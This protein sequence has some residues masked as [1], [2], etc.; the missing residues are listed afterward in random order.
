MFLYVTT[1]AQDT[2]PD[3]RWSRSYYYNLNVGES[4]I[5]DGVTIH[6]IYIDHQ[7]S[8]L[9]IEQDTIRLRVARR[10]LPVSSGGFQIFVAD[11]RNVANLTPGDPAHGLLKKDALICVSKINS[12][13]WLA[14]DQFIFPVSF[15]HGFI[16]K[17]DEDSYIFSLTGNTKDKNFTSYSGIGIDLND[18][19]GKEKHWLLAIENSNVVWVEEPDKNTACVL[20]ASSESP[21]VYYVYDKLYAKN[22]EVRK[23]QKLERGE[24]VGTAWGD[25]KWGYLQFAVVYAETAPDYQHR[26]DNCVNFFPQL[27][28]LYYDKT[29]SVSNFY[30]KGKI[31]FGRSES[32]KGNAKNASAF[33]EYL[34]KG[35]KPC[36]W[37]TAE[38]LESVSVGQEGNVR[39]S[40]TLFKGTP[41]E[42]KNPMSYCEYEI[43]VRNGVY[44]IRALVG[45][46]ELESWQ[47]VEFE[48]VV[49]GIY[50]LAAGEQ[51]WSSE[52]VVTVADNKL[53]VRIYLD[54]TGHKVAGLSELV[55]QQ[56]Y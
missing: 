54:E 42:C 56:A 27:F 22:L 55:F 4:V 30:T 1:V 32:Y 10:S 7:Y 35:W 18:V 46:V 49:A 38:K 25:D 44:R 26:F 53:T 33:E 48:N 50:P 41:A 3:F 16:W 14:K 24:L 36:S 5:F 13:N 2:E 9:L 43:N 28:G 37:N 47:K 11:N 17:G 23:G 34:G 19:R 51:Q 39:L 6:L 29:F 31:E 45:D 8:D 12:D 40:K 15:N 21:G 52:K 20:L